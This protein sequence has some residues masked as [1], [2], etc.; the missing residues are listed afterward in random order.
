[1]NFSVFV[2]SWAIGNQMGF[3]C[4]KW[5]DLSEFE[6]LSAFNEVAINY[7]K[8][9]WG[10]DEPELCFSDYEV[11]TGFDGAVNEHGISEQVFE[12]LKHI[13]DEITLKFIEY[14]GGELLHYSVQELAD[15]DEMAQNAYHGEADNLEDFAQNVVYAVEYEQLS[16]TN[17]IFANNIDWSGIALELGCY[18]DICDGRVWAL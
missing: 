13:D 18:Y 14:K 2:T 12:I 6:S 9:V 11:P 4:G 1:M 5:F 15:L 3:A 7:M 8:E 16:E 10:D 17:P